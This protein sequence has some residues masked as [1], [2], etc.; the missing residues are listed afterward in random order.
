MPTTT[1]E[2]DHQRDNE[3]SKDDRAG[4]SAGVEARREPIEREPVEAEPEPVEPE[5][6]EPGAPLSFVPHNL[7]GAKPIVIRTAR[8]GELEEHELLHL[9][10]SIEDE[11][12]R[13]R[14]RESI[15]IS[16]FIW[17]V[18]AWLLL[19]GP[20]YLWHA[21]ELL[22]PADVLKQRELVQLNAP[23]LSPQMRAAPK[24]T[25]KALDNKTLERLRAMKPAPTPTP[26]PAPAPAPEAAQPT[27]A[28]PP[29]PVPTPQPA[30]TPP[31]VVA[32]APTPQPP[33]RPSFG[34]QGSAG[35]SI[36]QAIRG[37]ASGAGST[38]VP[39]GVGRGSPI[40]T[41]VD[42]LSDTQGVNFNPYLAKI[43]REIYNQWIPLIPEEARPPLNKSGYTQ[44]RITIMPD[45]SLHVQ[46]GVHNGMVLESSTHDRALDEAAW[47][48]VTGVGQFPPLPKEFHGP[49]LELRIR[50]LVN[51][52]TE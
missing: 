52:P 42:I 6:V 7:A 41:G 27:P 31:P 8:Y 44:L 10:D 46:D 15:Y 1:P 4:V 18:V 12:A 37:A 13:S 14:F 45:G 2:R 50:Y 23:V 35:S 24:M 22:N 3:E 48:S 11:R 40:G 28:P 47:G 38:G 21:P 39:A 17:M 34:T 26:T 43:M 19:Y 36:Q 49:N 9:L 25:P 20:R 30:R 29:P 51:R 16:V 5:P 32:D 33:T